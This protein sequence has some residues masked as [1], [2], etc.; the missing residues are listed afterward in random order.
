MANYIKIKRVELTWSCIATTVEGNWSL[1]KWDDIKDV[2]RRVKKLEKEVEERSDKSKMT[3]D[4]CL[5]LQPSKRL[6]NYL[7]YERGFLE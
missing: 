3:Q 1:E 6:E 4:H 2:V 5:F 7:L